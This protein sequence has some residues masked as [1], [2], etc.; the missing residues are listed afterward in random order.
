MSIDLPSKADRKNLSVRQPPMDNQTIARHRKII[1]V[2]MDAFFASVE[3]LDNP[4]LRGKAVIVGGPAD[5]RGVVAACSYEA[6][7]FGIHSAMPSSR[8]AAL[9]PSAIFIRPRMSRYKEMSVRIMEI[10]RSFTDL[11]EPLSVDEAF[12]DVSQCRHHKGSATLI[13][14]EIRRRI[15]DETGLT[16]SAGVSCNK[17][18]A[19]VASGMNK[20]DGMTIILP[21]QALE[22]LGKLPIG[23]FFGVGKVTEQRMQKLG[24]N[25]GHDLR[26]L[27]RDELIL[28]FGKAG[29][30]FYDIVRCRDNRPV[31]P[32][33]VRKSIGSEITL[34][35]D[36]DD[37]SEMFDILQSLAES[38]ETA[39]TRHRQGG[40]T[41]TLKVRYRDFL[42]VTRSVTLS[43]P[44]FD[45]DEIFQH[46]PRLLHLTE[47]GRKKVRLLGISLAKLTEKDKKQ[48]RQLRLPFSPPM[49]PADTTGSWRTAKS[50]QIRPRL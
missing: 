9:C 16:A 2:D 20:P 12:L 21:D 25:T 31:Q 17:F 26:Q 24:I 15:F 29:A 1:H 39:L 35:Q 44:V 3:Q 40:S 32:T 8:A 23:K 48:P 7:R 50:T 10:F 38:V 33:H 49:R 5:S 18:L 45:R 27:T 41:I 42:T 37:F 43:A 11:V 28:H 34:D 6:R 47:A 19:K 4:E 13:A 36:T 30:F 14:S 46:L 22:F